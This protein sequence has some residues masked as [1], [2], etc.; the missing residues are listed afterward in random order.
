M[1]RL[2]RPPQISPRAGHVWRRGEITA[3]VSRHQRTWDAVMT[4]L[5]VIYVVVAI[6]DDDAP[7]SVPSVV[8]LVLSALFLIE[9][10]VRCWDAPSRGAY[11]RRHWIDAVSAIP[12]IGGLRAFRLL[13]LLRLGAAFRVLRVMDAEIR[14]REGARESLWFVAPSLLVLW[15]ASAYGIWA[16]EHGRNPALHS[17]GDALYWS[18]ITITTVGYG[19]I[20]PVTPEGRVLA[21]LLAFLG[22][23]L[24]GFASARLTAWWLRRDSHDAAMLQHLAAMRAEIA[25]LRRLVEERHALE[26]PESHRDAVDD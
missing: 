19:D 8:V 14:R 24:L 1:A 18:A 2:T 4:L 25:E 9:F 13:R 12:L 20:Q 3:F 15:V 16:L 21:G 6:R 23:G 22:I 26:A 10:T 11:V 5:A 7:G 17:F